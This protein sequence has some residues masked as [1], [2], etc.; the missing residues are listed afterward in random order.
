VTAASEILGEKSVVL[1]GDRASEAAVKAQPLQDFKIIHIAAHGIGAVMEPD[2]AAFV[3]APGNDREDGYW[4]AREIRR[5]RLSADLVT[6]SACESGIGRLQGE[7]GVMNIA[8]TFLVA[9][10]KSVLSSLWETDDRFTATV[11]THFYRHIADGES[12]AEALGAAQ[13]E[14]LTEFGKDTQPY[15]W[16][17]FMVIGDGTRKVFSET[18]RAHARPAR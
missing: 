9:G 4:Q 5:S 14:L 13:S 8:R 15:Y 6:L 11:M 17:G 3:L 12:A 1:T 7:E 2:R 10:A 18:E 16:A